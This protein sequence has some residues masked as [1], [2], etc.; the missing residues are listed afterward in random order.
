MNLWIF[1]TETILQ[2]CHDAQRVAKGVSVDAHPLAREMLAALI[3][4]LD[5]R[6]V[7]MLE[8]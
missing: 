5:T 3:V 8:N 2:M 6:G 4:E 7:S 1:E